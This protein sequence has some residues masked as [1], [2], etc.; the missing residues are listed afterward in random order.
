[1]TSSSK[2]NSTSTSTSTSATN[3]FKSSSADPQTEALQKAKILHQEL[4]ALLANQAKREAEQAQQPWGTYLKH[5]YKT[6]RAELINIGAAFLCLL[7]AVQIAGTRRLT[8][9]IVEQHEELQLEYQH[10]EQILTLLRDHNHNKNKNK[11]KNKNKNKSGF[12]R[13]LS[14]LCVDALQAHEQQKQQQQQQQKLS[15]SKS[16]WR[17]LTPTNTN[18]HMDDDHDNDDD[19]NNNNDFDMSDRQEKINI[20][21]PIV[22]NEIHRVMGNYGMTK[23]EQTAHELQL[24]QQMTS[25]DKDNDNNNNNNNN[26]MHTKDDGGLESLLGELQ[27][28]ASPISSSSSSSS[29]SQLISNGYDLVNSSS[30]SDNTTH[31]VQD[32]ASGET[33][34]QKTKFVM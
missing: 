29:S 2:S 15:K 30:S 13:H 28:A 20:V 16:L 17:F 24:I 33:K 4:E 12:T 14:E 9:Q 1:M 7:L 6:S 10:V 23:D 31:I 11:D 34:V 27:Q 25:K 8:K 3:K 22:R 19:N 26:N 5:L 32:D 21:M 18:N